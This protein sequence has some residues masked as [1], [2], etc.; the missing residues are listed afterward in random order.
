MKFHNF[1]NDSYSIPGGDENHDI[2]YPS[3]L[4][5]E[6]FGHGKGKIERAGGH[7]RSQG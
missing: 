6:V 4:I 2:R 1:S 3:A 5:E 7:K